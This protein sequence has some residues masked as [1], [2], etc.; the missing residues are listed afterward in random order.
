MRHNIFVVVLLSD[1][2]NSYNSLVIQW[3]LDYAKRGERLSDN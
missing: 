2:P 1:T 3:V